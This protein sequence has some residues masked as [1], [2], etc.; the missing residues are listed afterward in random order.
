MRRGGG[1]QY[2]MKTV[3]YIPKF[4]FTHFILIVWGDR[5]YRVNLMPIYGDLQ[6]VFHVY[7]NKFEYV[8]THLF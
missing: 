1:G 3:Q 7:L 5:D 6:E 2:V 4:K 8:I